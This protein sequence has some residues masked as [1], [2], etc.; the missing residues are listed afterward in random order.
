MQHRLRYISAKGV[1]VIS[2]ILLIFPVFWPRQGDHFTLRSSG[3]Q[4]L[5]LLPFYRHI[6]PLER[7]ETAGQPQGLPLQNS[8]SL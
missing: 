5:T 6:A 3:A 1:L 7:K 8:K 2:N 4:G